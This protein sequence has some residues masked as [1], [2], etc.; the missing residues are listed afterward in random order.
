MRLIVVS[1][2]RVK[3][4]RLVRFRVVYQQVRG[5]CHPRARYRSFRLWGGSIGRAKRTSGN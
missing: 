4:T 5:Y 2:Y 3:R 1:F